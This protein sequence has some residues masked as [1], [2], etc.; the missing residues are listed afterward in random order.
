VGDK[1]FIKVRP[2]ARISAGLTTTKNE[3]ADEIPAFNPLKIFSDAA[4]EEPT[5]QVA[6]SDSI[7]G[8]EV[9][10]EVLIQT[11]DFP[12][13]NAL[14]DANVELTTAEVEEVVRESARFLVSGTV[15]TAALSYVNPERFDFQAN[16]GLDLAALGVRI[17]PEN[18]TSVS[19]SEDEISNSYGLEEKI[20][21]VR[22]SDTLRSLL[23]D[24]GATDEE[25][26]DALQ[27]LESAFNP[28]RLREGQK[29]RV[30]Y[31]PAENDLDRLQPVRISIYSNQMH[32]ATIALADHGHF[33]LADE[34]SLE[35]VEED[36]FAAAAEEEEEDIGPRTRIYEGIYE[37]ALANEVPRN[38]IKQLIK[39][40]SFDVDFQRRTGPGDALE[41]F[42]ALEDDD[43]E[44]ASEVLYTSIT[45]GGQARRFYRFRTPDDGYVDYY[46]ETGKS[47]KKFLMRK[48]VSQGRFRS[49]FGYRRHPILRYTRM[50]KGVD[51][52]APRGTPIMAAGNGTVVE[53]KWKSGYGRWIKI[54][55]ANGYETGYAHQ[56]GF[57]RGIAPG[58]RV[59]QGQVIGY[60][61]STGLSTGPHL[62]YEVMVNGRNVDPM[63]IRLP[64]GRVLKGEVLASFEAE[65]DRIDTLMNR[66]PA[67]TRLAATNR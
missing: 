6:A 10:G 30:A 29:L 22:K 45:I 48:P 18:V 4:N 58:V 63:R 46:D 2:F 56:T 40:Y 11:K 31:A 14:V 3:Y 59:R 36:Q 50:H 65:R 42:Y 53:A 32:E 21:T 33:V 12:V 1:D 34:P 20:I 52:S 19:K 44:Q 8:A 9:E 24:N 43:S 67:S 23:K 27:A 15:H 26:E 55:H 13:D 7:Y 60:V 17:I 62:H 61:G 49:A 35:E 47:A 54:R 64:R 39:I 57:A 38:L 66:S 5:E 51:W 16:K 41:V 37:T 28:K 25:T